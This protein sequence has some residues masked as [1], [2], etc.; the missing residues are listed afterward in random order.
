MAKKVKKEVVEQQI[1]IPQIKIKTAKLTLIGNTWLMTQPFAEKARREIEG[2][3]QKKPKGARAARNPQKEYEAAFYR[4]P[5][6][7]NIYGIPAAGIK[8]CAVRACSFVDGI[9]MTTARG[10][11]HV[12]EGPGGLVPIKNSPP[13]YD[14]RPVVLKSGVKD[15]RYRPRFEKWSVTFDVQY[16]ENV[17]SLEQLVNLYNN[18]GFSVGLC[19]LR[20]ERGG[21]YGMFH[22]KRG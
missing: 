10:A 17:I 20:P 8:K 6:K 18:A 9:F 22:V 1:T 7:K 4:I 2:K 16:N 11:F 15:M 21:S 19:E 12:V 13:V 3:Q 5:G 14:A